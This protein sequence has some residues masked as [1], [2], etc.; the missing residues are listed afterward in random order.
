M[1]EVQHYTTLTVEEYAHMSHVILLLREQKQLIREYLE[2]GML[3]EAL[4]VA[5]RESE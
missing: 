4:D 2:K 3:A 1:T 5:K